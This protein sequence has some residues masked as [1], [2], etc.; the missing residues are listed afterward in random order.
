MA[1]R[2]AGLGKAL[3][4]Q[5]EFSSCTSESHYLRSKVAKENKTQI[6]TEKEVLRG[7]ESCHLS[8]G[9]WSVLWLLPGSRNCA[10]WPCTKRRHCAVQ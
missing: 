10:V 1:G 3:L 5:Q 4:H 7:I 8:D 6:Q 2:Q 9:Q